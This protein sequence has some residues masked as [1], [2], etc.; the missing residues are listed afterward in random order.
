MRGLKIAGP[1]RIGSVKVRV[2]EPKYGQLDDMTQPG[3]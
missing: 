1:P 2:E 3:C